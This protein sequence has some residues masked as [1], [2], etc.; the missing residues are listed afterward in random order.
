M[1]V[2]I[3]PASPPGPGL[4]GSADKPDRLSTLLFHLGKA[5]AKSIPVLGPFVEELVYEQFKD[6]LLPQV[7]RLSADELDRYLA[8]MAPYEIDKLEERF[9]ELSEDVRLAAVAQLAGVVSALSEVRDNFGDVRDRLEEL[10]DGVAQIPSIFAVVREIQESIDDRERLR[11]TVSEIEAKRLAGVAR[12]SANQR[13]LLAELGPAP[14]ALA[15]LWVVANHLMPTCSY[16]EF[17]FRLHELEWLGLLERTR[18]SR[19]W[20][21]Q[22]TA[23]G[24]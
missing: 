6:W 8:V 17:R 22:R 2:D 20:E 23:D 9:D 13:R 5:L 19:G 7:A 4:A 10:G 14:T 3:T 12:I 24:Q 11:R 18:T 15:D 21:Y 1:S 16:K